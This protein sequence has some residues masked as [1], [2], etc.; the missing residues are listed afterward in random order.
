MKPPLYGWQGSLF[1]WVG[2]FHIREVDIC[3]SHLLTWRG[4]YLLHPPCLVLLTMTQFCE[5]SHQSQGSL[6]N[7]IYGH[8]H[9]SLSQMHV[10]L[11]MST[12]MSH[13]LWSYPS[14]VD[15]LVDVYGRSHNFLLIHPR[16]VLLAGCWVTALPIFSCGVI[17]VSPPVE[18]G[19]HGVG[20]VLLSHAWQMPIH[21]G[22]ST[23]DATRSQFWWR[24][25]DLLH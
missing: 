18:V 17:S 12:A 19:L 8:R 25:H 23:S 4:T 3:S 2:V 10:F 13:Y 22:M 6:S 16:E 11:L 20:L 9:H 24:I 7:G 14:S 15:A 21:K 1:V 5:W